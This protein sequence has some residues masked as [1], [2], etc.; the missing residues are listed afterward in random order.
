MTQAPPPKDA[1]E[2]QLG[3]DDLMRQALYWVIRLTS[4]DATNLEIAAFRKWRDDRPEHAKAL[5]EAR[6]YWLMFGHVEGGSAGE[7]CA[8]PA[9]ERTRLTDPRVSDRRRTM[10]HLRKSGRVRT[11]DTLHKTK[12][13]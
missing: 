3:F 4:G 10:G 1:D 6:H 7:A 12:P 2:E 9:S 11:L 5:A 13:S 8:A